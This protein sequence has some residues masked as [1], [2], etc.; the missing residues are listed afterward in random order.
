METSLGLFIF[1]IALSFLLEVFKDFAQQLSQ[2]LIADWESLFRDSLKL[3][4]RYVKC[5]GVHVGRI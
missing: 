1:H 4:I 2:L 3:S 5:C